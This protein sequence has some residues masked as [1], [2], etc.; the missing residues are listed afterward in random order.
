MVRLKAALNAIPLWA[1]FVAVGVLTVLGYQPA[2]E[3]M[4]S[5]YTWIIIQKSPVTV[6]LMLLLFLWG[7]SV[8]RMGKNKPRWKGWALWAVGFVVIIVV[9]SVVGGYDTIFSM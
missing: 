1:I 6:N 9:Y 5:Q 8:D 3:V 2:R 7:V 4:I